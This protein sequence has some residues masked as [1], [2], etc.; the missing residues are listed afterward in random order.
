MEKW[1]ENFARTSFERSAD[2]AHDLKTPLNVAVLNLELLRMKVRKLV[3]GSDDQKLLDYAKS[4]ETELRRM[5]RIFDAYFLVCAPP[6]GEDGPAMIDVS[7]ICSEEAARAGFR[8]DQLERSMAL[9]H[10]SRIREAF[11]LFFQEAAKLFP[12]DQREFAVSRDAERISVVVSGP[13]PREDFE[14]TKLFKFYYTD[15][16]GQPD[17]SMATARL[18]LETYG[19]GLNATE[20]SDKVELRLSL[21]L[22]EE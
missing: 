14:P 7:V 18:I 9:I 10:E 6:K 15:S 11:R 1:L 8:M 4:I 3:E 17:L 5:A 12:T 13:R 22:G 20:E 2:T 16:S 19:G 21:P